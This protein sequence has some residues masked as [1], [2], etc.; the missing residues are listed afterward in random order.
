MTLDVLL[1]G[2]PAM[3]E[4]APYTV[5]RLAQGVWLI[6]DGTPTH[7][8]AYLVEGAD[9][10]VL[11]DTGDE[12]GDDIFAVVNRLTKLPWKLIVTHGHPDHAAFLDRV[13]EFYMSEKDIPLLKTFSSANVEN[14]KKCRGI[15]EGS[16]FDLGGV[17]LHTVEV[18][19]HSPGSVIF[20]DPCHGFIYTGDAFGSGE[21]VWMQTP[22][23]FTMT[24]YRQAILHAIAAIDSYFPDGETY[25]VLPGHVYQL[26]IGVPDFIPNPPCR[27]LMEDMAELC[28]RAIAGIAEEVDPKPDDTA[29]TEEPVT[30]INY[31]RASMVCLRSRF[32]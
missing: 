15:S 19:G 12:C 20:I 32:C 2:I 28:S 1:Q 29:F 25:I 11:I 5:R 21:G 3:T 22:M 4:F 30:R 24:Q 7:S 16:T 26:Y 6:E 10:A 9:S 17:V 27:A 23:G 13:D 18:E 8:C 31:N 14:A